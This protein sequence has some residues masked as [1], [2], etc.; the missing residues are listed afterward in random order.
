M[1]KF[2]AIELGC[3]AG[4]AIAYAFD[5]Y[6]GPSWSGGSTT[7]RPLEPEQHDAERTERALRIWSEAQPLAGLLAEST[8]T[9]AASMCPMKCSACSGFIVTAHSRAGERLR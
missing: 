4:E 1:I 7:A 5:N 6:L 3:S 2:I 9:I 8:S